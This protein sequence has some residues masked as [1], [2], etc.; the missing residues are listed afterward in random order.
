TAQT[1]FCPRGASPYGNQLFVVDFCSNRILKWNSIPTANQQAASVVLG[2]PDMTSID[3]NHAGTSAQTLSGPTS[4]S[5]DG[6]YV[7]VADPRANRVLLW[8]GVPSANQSSANVVLGQPNMSSS[9]R[10]YTAV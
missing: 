6:S 4:F 10:N 5:S 8:N 1:L 2:Q 3:V 7:A 9:G